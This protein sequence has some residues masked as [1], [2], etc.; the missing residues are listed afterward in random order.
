MEPDT[1]DLFPEP[2]RPRP[3]ASFVDDLHRD[4]RTRKLITDQI[5]A[6]LHESPASWKRVIT[7]LIGELEDLVEEEA[8]QVKTITARGAY[9]EPFQI[10][11]HRFGPV[12]FVTC[13]EFDDIGYFDSTEKAR[14]F[15]RLNSAEYL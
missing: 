14:V 7:A 13:N 11:I 8:V 3:L 4:R 5:V 10:Q 1:Y 12:R 15:A 6:R 2:L 9:E